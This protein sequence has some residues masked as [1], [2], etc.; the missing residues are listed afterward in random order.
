MFGIYKGFDNV[1]KSYVYEVGEKIVFW[2]R[3]GL[4]EK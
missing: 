4:K 2:N 1:K 3:E